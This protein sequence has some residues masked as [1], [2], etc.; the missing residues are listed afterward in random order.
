[1]GASHRSPWSTSSHSLIVKVDAEIPINLKAFALSRNNDIP[2][3]DITMKNFG[4]KQST[5]MR[6]NK[7]NEY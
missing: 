3:T 7:T 2:N 4:I 5:V 6:C 1:V